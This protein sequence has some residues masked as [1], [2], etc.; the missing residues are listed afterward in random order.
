MNATKPRVGSKAHGQLAFVGLLL[1]ALLALLPQLVLDVL[2]DEDLLSFASSA[3]RALF[4]L[5]REDVL[6]DEFVEKF[7]AEGGVF[8]EVLFVDGVEFSFVDD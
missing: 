2:V 1:E 8:D 3:L 5:N 7:L 6:V 4:L